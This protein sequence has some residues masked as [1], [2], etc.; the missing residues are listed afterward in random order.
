MEFAE[1][2][3]RRRKAQCSCCVQGRL[4]GIEEIVIRT[5]AEEATAL[6]GGCNRAVTATAQRIIAGS[7]ASI[8]RPQCSYYIAGAIAWR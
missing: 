8:V 5:M 1:V 7:S 6:L 4:F 2:S 3:L